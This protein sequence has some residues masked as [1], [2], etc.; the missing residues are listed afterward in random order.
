MT[1]LRSI[2][3]TLG[4][5][6]SGQQVLFPGPGHKSPRD[7]S[8][9]LKLSPSAPDGFLVFSY[10][11][12]DP[13]RVKDFVR[14]RLGLSVNVDGRSSNTA[15]IARVFQP[16]PNDSDRTVRAVSIWAEG[17]DPTGTPI[18]LYLAGRGIDIPDGA[19]GGV[20]RFHPNCPFAG[21]RT[22]AMLSLVRDIRTNEP[23]AVHR[24]ALTSEG[25]QATIDGKDRLALGPIAGGAIKLTPDQ[26]VTICLGIGEGIETALSLRGLP[27]L[28]RLRFGR[29]SQPVGSQR[30]RFCQGSSAYG[31]PSTMIPPAQ[32]QPRHVQSGGK[33]S[34]G[35]SSW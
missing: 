35:K 13:L 7:R 31:S 4:G 6:V 30:S 11:G 20:I 2:A 28:A 21:S 5:T 17:H 9:S 10:S 26:D 32:R 3:R 16:V 12:D 23:R 33:P 15:P 34:D 14:A 18:R 19:A 27:N 29:L 22:P 8:A 25:Q 24:T 1:D